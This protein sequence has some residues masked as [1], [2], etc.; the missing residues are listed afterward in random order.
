[1]SR[2]IHRARLL[3]VLACL[4]CTAAAAQQPA[5]VP[6]GYVP[7]NSPVEPGHAPKMQVHEAPADVRT[8]DLRFADGDEILSGIT[9]LAIREHISA[10]YVIGIG[11]LSSAV[12]GFGDPA[13]G[14]IK[15]IPVEQK[16]ELASLTGNITIRNGRPVVHAH[17]V[18]GLAD[19][20]SKAG[21]VVSAHVAPIAEV[22]VVATELAE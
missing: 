16:S 9:E 8:F 19:G 17:A 7:P 14:A 2:A 12:L 6:A 22:T 18:L 20:S 4:G 3:A 11:G 5:R 1:M 15:M 10:G 21:H 13:V